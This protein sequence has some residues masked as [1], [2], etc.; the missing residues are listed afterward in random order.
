MSLISLSSRVKSSVLLGFLVALA[1]A[2]S[3]PH[4]A[5]TA[6]DPGLAIGLQPG[7]LAS[8]ESVDTQLSASKV[9]AGTAVTVTCIGQ[10]GE[11]KITHPTFTSTPDKDV[12]LASPQLTATKTGIYTVQCTLPGRTPNAK[13]KSAQL[14]V[15]AGLAATIVTTITPASIAAGDVASATCAAKDAFGNDTGKNADAVWSISINPPDSGVVTDM[16][17]TGHTA[18]ATAVSCALD[19]SPDAVVTPATLTITPGAAVTTSAAIAPDTFEAGAGNSVV[20]CAAKDA[21]GNAVDASAATLSLPKNLDATGNTVTTTVSGKY[22]IRCLLGDVA[23]D[24]A[25]AVTLTVTPGAPISMTLRPKPFAKFYKIDDTIK[26]FGLGKDKYGNDVPDMPLVQPLAVD[27]PEGVTVNGGGLSYSFNTDG[28][29]HFAGVSKD[30]PSLAAEITLTCDSVGPMVL[31][32]TPVRGATLNGSPTV[33]VQGTVIDVTSGVKSFV[34][35]N[36]PVVVAGDGSFSLDMTSE[37]GMNLIDWQ[38]NDV[39]DNVSTGVQSYYYSTKWYVSDFNQP[40]ESEISDAIGIWLSQSIL[41]NPP[42]NHKTPG[43]IATVME[44]VLGT[45]DFSSLLGNGGFPLSFSQAGVTINGNVNIKNVKMGDPNVNDGYPEVHI[46]VLKGGVGV[47]AKIYKFSADLEMSVQ[48]PPLPAAKVTLQI[49]ADEIDVGMDIFLAKD[50]TTGKLVSSA[51]NTSIKFKNFSILPTGPL[52]QFI[53]PILK[54]LEQAILGP[55]TNALIAVL[56]PQLNS[57]I[58]TALGSA[59]SAFAINTVVPLKPFIGNG[60]EAQLKLVTD[61]GTLNFSEKQGI[62]LGLA[63]SMTADKKVAHEVL[64]SIGRA[65]C[66]AEKPKPEVFNP[67]EKYGLELGIADDFLNQLLHAVWNGGV[68]QMTLDQSVIGNATAQFGISDMSI[69]TDF[70]LPPIANECLPVQIKGNEAQFHFQIGD[71][72]MHALLTFGGTPIDMHAF[73][74]VQATIGMKVAPL[75]NDPTTTAISITTVNIDSIKM[76]IVD[77]N[78]EAESLKDTF[79]SLITNVVPGLLPKLLGSSLSAIQ[80]PAI[81]LSTLSPQIPKGTLLTFSLQDL[82]NIAGYTY[83]RGNLKQ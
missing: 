43:D 76:E 8:L 39:W 65:S 79:K 80:L 21:F 26:M 56:E 54:P 2:C 7:Q 61:I 32:T 33:H 18:G 45:I 9:A 58:G 53:N 67:T 10:P 4:A 51:K 38:A 46:N 69:T 40:K 49:A 30:Y 60:P 41:D 42:H 28:H 22:D 16:S 44:I 6:V 78:K 36:Q 74:S 50:P 35:N 72:G 82:E 23:V 55:L 13:D 29:Y 11:V 64:G 77:I 25:T 70:W 62:I 66:L 81:D 12:T 47:E 52:A 73:L 15:T 48:I 17:V 75:P 83:I 27:P 3:D 14:A 20:T 57:A 24:M 63:A 71:M 34:V 19:G 37:W 59:L 31:I 68:L 1:T 5:D